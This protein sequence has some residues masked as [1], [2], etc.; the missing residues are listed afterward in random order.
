[1][2]RM[3]QELE[4]LLLADY[5]ERFEVNGSEA[6]LI[7]NEKMTDHPCLFGFTKLQ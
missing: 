1:M 2:D 4:I 6:Y 3:H 5:S 7:I